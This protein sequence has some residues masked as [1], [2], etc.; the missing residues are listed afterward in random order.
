MT[1]VGAAAVWNGFYDRKAYDDGR[2]R[3]TYWHFVDWCGSAFRLL[4]LVV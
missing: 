1:V 2:D 3:G 4:Y